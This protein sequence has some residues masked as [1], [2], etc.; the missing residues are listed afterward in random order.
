MWPVDK[1]KGVIMKCSISDIG[2]WCSILGFVI[3]IITFCV[4]ANVNAKIN[5][6]QKRKRD[7]DYFYNKA[8]NI[9]SELN[10]MRCYAE[11]SSDIDKI[12][13]IKQQSMIKNA[14]TVIEE[15]WSVLLPNENRIVKKIKIYNWNKKFKKI[16]N[17]YNGV[18]IKRSEELVAFLI[19]ITTFL[20]KE[21]NY[22]E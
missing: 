2:N 17:M 13:G 6:M 11:S 12:F 7:K 9:I 19:E 10:D 1:E 14:V 15:S 18:K 3:T 22:N 16:L 5:K 4:A 8:P 21:L 20:E